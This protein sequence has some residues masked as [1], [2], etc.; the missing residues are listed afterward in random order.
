MIHLPAFSGR[1]FRIAR[2]AQA[3]KV[4]TSNQLEF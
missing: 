2:K 4:E 3:D 1:I